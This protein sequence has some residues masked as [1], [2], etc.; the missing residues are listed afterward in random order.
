MLEEGVH[1]EELVSM[2]SALAPVAVLSL[3]LKLNCLH[4]IKNE[5]TDSQ[6]RQK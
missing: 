6:S 4:I 5:A 3:F 2:V 1:K